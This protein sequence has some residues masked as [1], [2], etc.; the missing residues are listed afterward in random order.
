MMD[1][2]NNCSEFSF[3]LHVGTVWNFSFGL[4]RELDKKLHLINF[5]E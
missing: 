4:K 3:K 1:Q 5:L 2:K